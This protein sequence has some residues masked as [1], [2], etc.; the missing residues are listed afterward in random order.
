M[1]DDHDLLSG[2]PGEAVVKAGLA[3]LEAGRR[4]VHAWLVTVARHRLTQAG[5]LSVATPAPPAGSTAELELYR[6]LR[7]EGGDAYA[8]YNALVRELVSFESGLALR[9]RRR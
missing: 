4:T 2:L 7:Q 1:I 9:M 8:R 5:V 3:D 6:L